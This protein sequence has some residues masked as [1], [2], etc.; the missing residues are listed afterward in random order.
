MQMDLLIVDDEIGHRRV[1]S[2][3]AATHGLQSVAYESGVE[4]L[5]YLRGCET[6]NLFRGYF[7]DMK[8]ADPLSGVRAELEAPLN[9]YRYL[10]SVD[11]VRYFWFISAHKS[12]HD[13]QVLRETGAKFLLKEDIDGIE[14]AL[15]EL[16]EA[17]LPNSRI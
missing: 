17:K 3:L 8:L 1:Y 10:E 15:I 5:N 4:A 7:V 12:E 16:K 14:K 6:N 9:I 11:A 2:V 13:E